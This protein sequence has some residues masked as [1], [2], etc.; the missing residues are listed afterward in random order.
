MKLLPICPTHRKNSAN[1]FQFAY[2]YELK[3]IH[4]WYRIIKLF[5]DDILNEF[6]G[7][8]AQQKSF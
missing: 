1:Y 2:L 3:V 6:I 8:H 5:G 4:T 7:T